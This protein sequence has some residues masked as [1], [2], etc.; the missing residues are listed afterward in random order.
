MAAL[1]EEK[2]HYQEDN[3]KLQERINNSEMMDDT[4][5]SSGRKLQ[6]LQHQVDKQSDEIYRLE[7][8]K[9][10]FIFLSLMPIPLNL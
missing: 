3:R 5:S 1:Q 7:A 9:L 4:G 8:G 6:Q 10:F 2:I